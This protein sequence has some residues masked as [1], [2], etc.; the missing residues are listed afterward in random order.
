MSKKAD[1]YEVYV[2][3]EFKF[4]LKIIYLRLTKT[5]CLFSLVDLRQSI[6]VTFFGITRY[7]KTPV[8]K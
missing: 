1:I 7:E 3:Q 8:L 6:R 2:K 4:L 5:V